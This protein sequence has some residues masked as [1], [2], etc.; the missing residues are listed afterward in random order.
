[1]EGIDAK[2][3]AFSLELIDELPALLAA[4]KQL[5]GLNVTTPYKEA[6]IPYLDELHPDAAAIAAVNCIA[7]GDGRL[8]GYNTD[9]AAFRDSIHPLLKPYH[10][11]ALILGTGGASRAVRYAFEQMGIPFQTVS[12]SKEKA[13]LV[14]EEVSRE[15][16]SSIPI[17]VNTTTLG[18]MGK[19]CPELPYDAITAA[20]LLYDLVYNPPLPPFLSEGQCR[21]AAVMN[22]Q[23]M[24]ALQA[25]ASWR[26]WEAQP[27]H[28][29]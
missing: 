15:L 23:Q 13:D 24:L 7:V 16:L 28:R 17:I 12:R 25:E 26:I 19:G 22:G 10:V 1:M 27:G 20:H 2:Y 4:D 11:K 3:S 14:Y 6:V 8:T 21:G 29:P 5:R 18:T 9:W